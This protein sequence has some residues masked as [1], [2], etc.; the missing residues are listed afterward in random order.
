MRHLDRLFL[1]GCV[2]VLISC[3]T[4]KPQEMR[5][6]QKV[7]YALPDRLP[8]GYDYRVSNQ[9]VTAVA[10]LAGSFKGDGGLELPHRETIEL[11]ARQRADLEHH[12]LL[13]ELSV[14]EGNKLLHSRSAMRR[15]ARALQDV[16]GS[17]PHIRAVHL[18]FEY[19]GPGLA[20]DYVEL[21][22]SL[23]TAMPREIKLYVTVIPM[24][25]M[26]QKW[27]AFF[28]PEQL[29]LY[30]DGIVLMLYDL[31]RDGTSAG[32]LSPISWLD[33]NVE[34]L[35]KLPPHKIWL[36]APLYGYRFV[37]KKATVLSKRAF[38]KITARETEVD[39]CRVKK[40]EGVQ[41]Y[42]PAASLYAHYEKLATTHGFAGITYWRA[43]L[44]R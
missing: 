22:H 18:D 17:M 19:N 34:E 10:W 21:V 27:S 12:L 36:G 25:G 43:G 15:A 13:T 4:K 38:G 23:R 16:L 42:Y 33:A 11:L 40:S 2:L 24:V 41:A 29:T 31:H 7:L 3:G 20:V 28:L 26:P 14:S 44:E 6:L 35:S 37:G 32:C 8:E 5:T 1:C 30:A 39:G 9:S